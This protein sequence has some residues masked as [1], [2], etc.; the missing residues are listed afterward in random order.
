[1]ALVCDRSGAY[2]KTRRFAF[3][4]IL[5]RMTLPDFCLVNI[6]DGCTLYLKK[7]DTLFHFFSKIN[8][9]DDFRHIQN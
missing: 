8:K 1:M 3:V 7:K 5:V 6:H 4:M 2:A 9:P